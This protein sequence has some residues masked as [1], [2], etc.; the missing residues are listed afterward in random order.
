MSQSRT[1]RAARFVSITLQ[2]PLPADNASNSLRF[3]NAV[4]PSTT[5]IRAIRIT[6]GASISF[7]PPIVPSRS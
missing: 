4:V 6:T 7:V 5:G 2:L 3:G 1:R